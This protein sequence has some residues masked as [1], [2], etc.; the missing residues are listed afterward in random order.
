MDNSYFIYSQ[1]NN[2]V[3]IE[4]FHIC[5]WEFENNSSFIEFGCE[6]NQAS[7]IN[8]NNLELALLVPWLSDHCAVSDFYDNL[9][10]PENSRFIFNDSILNTESLDG[11]QNLNGVI[12]NFQERDKLCI[13]PVNLEKNGSARIIKISVNLNFYNQIPITSKK[14]NI[15]FRF[16]ITPEKKLIATRKN[17]ITKA[18]ILYDIRLNQKRNLPQDLVQ[19][20]GNKPTC[21]VERC[22]CF[23]IVP[24][25][26]DLVFFDSLSLQNVRTL[27]YP[28]FNRYLPDKRLKEN[29]LI[30][31]YNKKSGSD[32]YTFFLIFSKEFIGMDQLAIGVIISLISGILLFLPSYRISLDKNMSYSKLLFHMPF[33]FWVVVVL[34]LISFCYFV[35]KQLKK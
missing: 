17:G 18:T 1:D 3:L 5:T 27:E 34:V 12:H 2:E 14:P 13:L 4:R 25:R 35:W 29:E 23:N 10:G 31:I 19:K 11:G 33:L 32:P 28:S 7:I 21:K 24:N 6:I 30:V 8:K 20:F 22:F 16:S 9:K 26:Y 15:Y